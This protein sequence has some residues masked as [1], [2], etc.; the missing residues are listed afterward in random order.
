[1]MRGAVH[2]R[3]LADLQPRA[4][5]YPRLRRI[6]EREFDP[7]AKVL[8]F[9]ETKRNC[10]RV[11]RRCGSG[12]AVFFPRLTQHAACTAQLTQQLRMDRWPALCMH[13]DKAQPERDW[14]MNEYRS[15]RSPILV[16][17]DVAAR[18]LGV[19]RCSGS[20][21][22]SARASERR[23][24]VL[25]RRQGGGSAHARGGFTPHARRRCAA[26]AARGA[27]GGCPHLA[28]N[29]SCVLRHCGRLPAPAAVAVPPPPWTTFASEQQPACF[30]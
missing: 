2:V 3:N 13:G 23:H 30:S 24:G 4:F 9:T 6:L 20:R 26:A 15:G 16:A 18:G 19:C 17:T 29:A 11:R 1:M 21:V 22:S 8:I 10:D 27:R 5:Q 25:G 28:R 14:V 7:R 12:D